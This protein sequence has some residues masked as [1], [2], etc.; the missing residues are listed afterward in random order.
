[1]P[2]GQPSRARRKPGRSPVDISVVLP[3]LNE[4][5]NVQALLPRLGATLESLG[6][7]YELLIVDG[8]SKD[9]TG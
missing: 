2:S 7:T 9:G 3:V 4:R 1:M 6:L 8:G 5:E